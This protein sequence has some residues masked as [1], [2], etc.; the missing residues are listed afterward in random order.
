MKKFL[1]L[2]MVFTS[3]KSFACSGGP[4]YS[5]LSA[6]KNTDLTVLVK[7]KEYVKGETLQYESMNVEVM[8]VLKGEEMRKEIRIYGA[9]GTSCRPS[10]TGFPL[11][12][13]WLIHLSKAMKDKERSYFVYNTSE[14]YLLYKNDS[15]SGHIMITT[16]CEKDTTISFDLLK[17]MLKQPDK[18]L[19]PT[20]KCYYENSYKSKY[21]EDSGYVWVEKMPEYK[22]G[23]D[24]LN[25]L[26]IAKLRL[27][28]A[29]YKRYSKKIRIEFN[30][31][32]DGTISNAKKAS[33]FLYDKTGE[34]YADELIKLMNGLS[35]EW[36]PGRHFNILC[37]VHLVYDIDLKEICRK[38]NGG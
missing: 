23:I 25:S 16:P 15:I 35:G 33:D 13:V 30:V 22:Y 24:S 21:Y 3:L 19:L 14:D 11:S 8:E 6:S 4:W 20:K 31:E 29:D 27:R 26:I 1:I 36:I 12:S 34:L 18:Y 38:K 37:R 28:P 2:I 10:V 32:K 9:D 7:V 17:E 5:F